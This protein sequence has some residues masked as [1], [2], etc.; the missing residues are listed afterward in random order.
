MG[1]LHDDCIYYDPK[2]CIHTE[3]P[4]SLYNRRCN[5]YHKRPPKQEIEVWAR[6]F[7]A[8]VKAAMGEEA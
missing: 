3:G 8:G 6:G 5:D 4:I 2:W 7:A 1:C